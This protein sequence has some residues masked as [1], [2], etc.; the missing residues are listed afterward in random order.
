MSFFVVMSSYRK[1]PPSL[2]FSYYE[3]N[4]QRNKGVSFGTLFQGMPISLQADISLSLYKGIID[5]VHYLPLT[6]YTTCGGSAL[7]LCWVQVPLFQNTEIGFT[8]LLALSIQPRFF[9][10]KEYIVKKGDIGSEVGAILCSTCNGTLSS[11]PPQMFFINRGT[12]EVVSEDGSVVF[13]TMTEGKF[14]GEIS[15]VFSC[16][17][18]ASI[19]SGYAKN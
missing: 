18:T 19:R 3:Y 5:Q 7:H 11:L 8:K 9:L 12:V 14:F 4:W 6:M 10:S 17:R 1:S 2:S 15:L 16:P 13:A